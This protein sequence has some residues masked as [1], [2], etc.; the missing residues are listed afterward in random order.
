M[1]EGVGESTLM[2]NG[3]MVWCKQELTCFADTIKCTAFL[4]F[5]ERQCDYIIW[6][7]ALM[8]TVI[9]LFT[10]AVHF[11]IALAIVCAYVQ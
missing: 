3:E 5:V 10:R 9:I 1:N 6:E 4:S 2:F 7:I 11:I 8:H